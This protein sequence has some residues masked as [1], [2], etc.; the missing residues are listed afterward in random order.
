MAIDD[1]PRPLAALRTRRPDIAE[2]VLTVEGEE[3]SDYVEW[4]DMKDGEIFCVLA[5]SGFV[6]R[7][8]V[9]QIC[10][11][12]AETAIRLGRKARAPMPVHGIFHGRRSDRMTFAMRRQN[13][14]AGHFRSVRVKPNTSLLKHDNCQE[15]TSV[16]AVTH[17]I[18]LR[19][20][21]HQN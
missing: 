12:P 18:E 5:V 3:C 17:E 16:E 21:Q 20:P 14:A 4:F 6:E 7:V 2:S 11:S 8:A 19:W 9:W 10:P 15:P 13:D 1:Q